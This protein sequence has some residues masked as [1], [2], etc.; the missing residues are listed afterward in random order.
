[1]RMVKIWCE[2]TSDKDKDY[3]LEGAA[4]SPDWGG[5]TL[6][7]AEAAGA[8]AG[9]A[10]VAVLGAWAV[11]RRVAAYERLPDGVVSGTA[12]A[13]GDAFAA[14]PSRRSRFALG[15]R[16]LSEREESPLRSVSPRRSWRSPRFDPAADVLWAAFAFEGSDCAGASKGLE[17]WALGSV[18]DATSVTG[19]GA[20]AGTATGLGSSALGELKRRSTS[21][22][23]P[24]FSLRSDGTAPLTI[25]AILAYKM[26]A[27]SSS[28]GGQTVDDQLE[29]LGSLCLGTL[30]S[31]G[32][33]SG[34]RVGV[35]SVLGHE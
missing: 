21:K 22:Q 4:G 32:K 19:A 34:S 20:G 16:R 6:A 5:R 9:V 29:A 10:G 30:A 27:R 11:A 7:W 28:R 14:P 17:G 25:S 8:D 2:P 13:C 3:E 15:R 33:Y 23:T 31:G 18:C 35:T 26:S 1:M 12:D 24:T